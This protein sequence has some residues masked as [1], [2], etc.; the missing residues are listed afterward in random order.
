[1][2]RKQQYISFVCVRLFTVTYFSVLRWSKSKTLRCG[3]PHWHIYETKMAVRTG[4]RS[5]LIACVQTFPLPQ[6]KSGEETTSSLPIF[7]EGGGT[8]VHRLHPDDLTRK[9]GTL[10]SLSVCLCLSFLKMKDKAFSNHEQTKLRFK[11]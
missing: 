5:I 6:E 11:F 3:Q 7:P 9:Y 8:S 1:M 10:N 4:K 2:K